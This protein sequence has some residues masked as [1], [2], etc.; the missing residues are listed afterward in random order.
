MFYLPTCP[1]CGTVYRYQ[2]TKDA[3]KQKEN[4]CYHCQQKF[5]AKRFPYIIIGAMLPLI[6]CIGINLFL[7]SRMENLQLLPLFA[8][9]FVFLLFIYIIVPFFTKFKKSTDEKERKK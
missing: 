5:I 4:I 9:T 7:L 6:L 3:I 1:H 8:V 2:D